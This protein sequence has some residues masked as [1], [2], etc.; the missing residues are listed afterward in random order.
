MYHLE[1][2]IR[3]S[4]E[5]IISMLKQKQLKP[6]FKGTVG[7]Q[8]RLKRVIPRVLLLLLFFFLCQA[9]SFLLI[10]V[11]AVLHGWIE[12]IWPNPT[13]K[14]KDAIKP[15]LVPSL[16]ESLIWKNK[17]LFFFFIWKRRQVKQRKNTYIRWQKLGTKKRSLLIFVE[18]ESSHLYKT[19]RFIDTLRLYGGKADF[20]QF[21]FGSFQRVGESP[22]TYSS[23]PL[24]QSGS[25]SVWQCHLH[26]LLRVTRKKLNLFMTFLFHAIQGPPQFHHLA[27]IRFSGWGG[28][29]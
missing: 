20:F 18:E 11:F 8:S 23:G 19:Q 22:R 4:K 12:S 6:Q 14:G 26:L 10:H 9:S 5:S 15:R 7:S 17:K 2:N 1:C 27:S 25:L 29:Y 3:S 28:I 16:I 24:S 13:G 21:G